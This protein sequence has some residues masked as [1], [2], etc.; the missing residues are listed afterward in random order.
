[1][2][3]YVLAPQ[4]PKT[5]KEIRSKLYFYTKALKGQNYHVNYLSKQ[6]EKY[7]VIYSNTLLANKLDS[8]HV[9]TAKR[10]FTSCVNEWN[11]ACDIL[12][13]I[14]FGVHYWKKELELFKQVA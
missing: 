6:M 3:H 13:E 1:M 5:A 9:T 10:D 11:N 2:E 14:E 8:I 7:R 12:D 4:P